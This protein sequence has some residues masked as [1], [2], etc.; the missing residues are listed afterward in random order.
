MKGQKKKQP[1]QLGESLTD[2]VN[3]NGT[4]VKTMG[5]E[6]LELQ[7]YGPH[8]DF[9]GIVDITSQ[10]QVKGSNTDGR[11][12]DVVD[13]DIFAFESRMHDVIFTEQWRI[14]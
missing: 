13:S 14:W 8:E 6:G 10:N 11:I 12:R 5:I 2:C 9:G 3:G 4:A 1:S 7:A